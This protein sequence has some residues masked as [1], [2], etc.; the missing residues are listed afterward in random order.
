MTS[1]NTKQEKPI[2]EEKKT[3]EPE[4]VY[5]PNEFKNDGLDKLPNLQPVF[6]NAIVKNLVQFIL[7]DFKGNKAQTEKWQKFSNKSAVFIE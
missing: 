1:E 2:E 3:V 5:D 4:K 6:R 7:L